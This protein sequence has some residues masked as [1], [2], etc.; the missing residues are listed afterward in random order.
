MR[1]RDLDGPEEYRTDCLIYQ[2]GNTITG[3]LAWG[4]RARAICERVG[5][6]KHNI[7]TSRRKKFKFRMRLTAQQKGMIR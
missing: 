2:R 7:P 1:G 5:G 4:D 3:W 6:Y